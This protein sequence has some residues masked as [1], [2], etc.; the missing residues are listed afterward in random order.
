[1]NKVA[2]DGKAY[3]TEQKQING[4]AGRVGGPAVQKARAENTTL[5]VTEC[6][7]LPL[8]AD[9]DLLCRMIWVNWISTAKLTPRCRR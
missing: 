5:R 2:A 4:K 3:G 1:M 8:C 6:I 9:G 7:L